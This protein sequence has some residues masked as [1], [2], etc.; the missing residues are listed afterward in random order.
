MTSLGRLLRP[1]FLCGAPRSPSTAIAM[2]LAPTLIVL[3]FHRGTFFD[4]VPFPVDGHA[5]ISLDEAVNAQY[6]GRPAV[7][8]SSHNLGAALAADRR[9]MQRSFPELLTLQ[10]GSI[11]A[12]CQSIDIEFLNNENSVML[13]T[14]VALRLMP[15][16]TPVGLGRLL[17]GVRLGCVLVFGYVLLLAGAPL[18]LTTLALLL[19]AQTGYDLRFFNY[20]IYSFFVPLL[21]LVPAVFALAFRGVQRHGASLL[22]PFCVGAGFLTA[23]CV[24]MRSSH[25]PVY[26]ALFAAFIAAVSRYV[27]AGARARRLLLTMAAAAFVIG[28]IAFGRAFIRPLVPTHDTAYHNYSHHVIAHPLVLAL[29]VPESEFSHRHGIS[30]NDAVG[31]SLARSM[32]PDAVYLGP[33]YEEGLFLYYARL[34]LTEPAAMRQV[35]LAKFRT[36]GTGM[37]A[38]DGEL[39]NE[40]I[41]KVLRLGRSVAGSG[42]TLGALYLLAMLAAAWVFHR[43]R[44]A[45]PLLVL[46]LSLVGMLLFLESAV[47]MSIFT[48]QYDAYLLFWTA[49]LAL[50]V[51]QLALDRLV[52]RRARPEVG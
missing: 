50:L 49:L 34:W 36:A 35:Y 16:T 28:Y 29:G 12:Y 33:G 8:A 9:L 52:G 14:R 1:I 20:S 26:A 7:L 11:Q 31:P 38:P 45:F 48:V 25:L 40:P 17:G 32:V 42:L 22:I 27:G 18:L 24:N 13:L 39:R 21:L 4:K 51:V 41:A 37:F 43:R 2:L 15:N 6:C 5:Y 47:I 23:F 3:F 44:A 19:A 30:W 10:A 46:L